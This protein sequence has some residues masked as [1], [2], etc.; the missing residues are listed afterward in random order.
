MAGGKRFEKCQVEHEISFKI[1]GKLTISQLLGLSDR[2][3]KEVF[4]NE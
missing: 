2:F 4:G 1:F 3:P